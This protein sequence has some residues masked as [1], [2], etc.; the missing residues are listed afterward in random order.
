MDSTH[1]KPE[2]NNRL[3]RVMIV[4]IAC[5]SIACWITVVLGIYYPDLSSKSELVRN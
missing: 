2:S 3:Y 4:S 5:V 1:K